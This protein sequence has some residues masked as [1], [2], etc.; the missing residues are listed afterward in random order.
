MVA[1]TRS[2]RPSLRRIA[3]AALFASAASANAQDPQRLPRIVI[4]ADS[5]GPGAKVL[6]GTVRDTFGIPVPGAEI[7]IGTLRKRVFTRDDGTFR[8]EDMRGGKWP[9]RARKLGYA[10]LVR[11]I[12]LESDGAIG[13]FELVP[14][15]YRMPAVVTSAARGGLSGIIADTGY[16]GIPG[17]R[18][19]VSGKWLIAET[20]SSG[21]FHIAAPPGH[22]MIA[23]TKEGFTDRVA[24]VTIPDDSGKHMTAMLYPYIKPPVREFW[25]V[26]DLDERQMMR[27]KLKQPFLTHADIVEMGFVWIHDLVNA[28]GMDQY[29]STCRVIVNGGPATAEL[30]TLTVDDVDAVEIYKASRFGKPKSATRPVGLARKEIAGES[31]GDLLVKLNNTNEANFFNQAPSMNCVTVYVWLR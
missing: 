10:P 6:V 17:V 5:T 25:N 16:A 13:D 24:S 22:Y 28:Q 3:V 30:A 2:V 1:L 23:M 19:K 29:S 21:A 4:K 15:P 9:V 8:I 31:D 11:E 27:D 12:R 14:W 7:S 26:K 18:V 20:D